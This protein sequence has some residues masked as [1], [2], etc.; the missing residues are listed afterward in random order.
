MTTKNLSN[1]F[2]SEKK[3]ETKPN[4]SSL[5]QG[6]TSLDLPPIPV[7]IKNDFREPIFETR[8]LTNSPASNEIA[9]LLDHLSLAKEEN[10]EI[11]K[12]TNAAMAQIK[13]SNEM[14]IST[15]DELIHLLT[16]KIEKLN[17]YKFNLENELKKTH[18]RNE[19]LQILVNTMVSTTS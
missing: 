6:A 18:G 16:E 14:V 10:R 12:L 7:K 2:F 19:D 13:S 11:L 17:L 8:V 4:S 5:R 1:E 9:L 3:F 15:K